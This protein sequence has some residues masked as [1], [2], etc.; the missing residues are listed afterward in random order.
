MD[1]ARLEIER[2]NQFAEMS[3]KSTD[4]KTKIKYSQSEQECYAM[5]WTHAYKLNNNFTDH[6]K[7]KYYFFLFVLN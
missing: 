5:T 7:H 2:L 6:L 3:P 1:F 4:N